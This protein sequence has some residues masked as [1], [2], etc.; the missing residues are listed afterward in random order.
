M[1]RSKA[2]AAL[3]DNTYYELVR[4]FPLKPLSNEKELATAQTVM[5]ELVDR[6][7]DDLTEGEEAYLDV[8]SDLVKKYEDRNHAIPDASPADV[9][10][11]LIDDRKTSQRAVALGSG[12]SVSTISEILG[13]GRALNLDHVTKLATHFKVEPGVFIPRQTGT[14]SKGKRRDKQRSR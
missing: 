7:F 14:A 10:R 5:N 12:I 2:S 6:G 1:K 9:L 13:G 4:R 11:F 8:L 3:A